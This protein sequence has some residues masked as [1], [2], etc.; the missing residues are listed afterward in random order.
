V[1]DEILEIDGNK[2]PVASSYITDKQVG[3]IIKV[4]VKRFGREFTYDV[5]L[6]PNPSTRVK[7]ERV[8]N[9]TTEQE[10]LYKKWLFI[11]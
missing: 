3:D 7:L 5:K 8:Q 4:K 10:E 9:P 11:K 1:N 6:M 2:Y